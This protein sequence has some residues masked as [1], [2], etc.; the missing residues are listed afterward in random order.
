M[1]TTIEKRTGIWN[2]SGR[3]SSLRR[4][5]IA[6]ANAL[7]ST[8]ALMTG[9]GFQ[10]LKIANPAMAARQ[11]VRKLLARSSFK[12]RQGGSERAP[13][14]NAATFIVVVLEVGPGRVE[15]QTLP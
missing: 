9:D 7:V 14:Y 6:N 1:T 11:I 13:L 4:H 10:A 8:T 12:S 3:R 2:G 15:Q 5:T